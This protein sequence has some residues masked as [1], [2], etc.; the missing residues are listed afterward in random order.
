MTRLIMWWRWW[1]QDSLTI[2]TVRSMLTISLPQFVKMSYIITNCGN[3]CRKGSGKCKPCSFFLWSLCALTNGD[4]SS[5][6]LRSARWRRL[7]RRT[8]LKYHYLHYNSSYI[9]SYMIFYLSSYMLLLGF[10]WK[11]W[12]EWVVELWVWFC[13]WCNGLVIVGI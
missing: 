7:S 12:V 6:A 5:C 13:R 9:S 3:M 4:L 8:I 10:H 11:L 2:D 1:L